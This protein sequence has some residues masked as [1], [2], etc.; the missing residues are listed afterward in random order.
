MRDAGSLSTSDI[1]SAK[2]REQN[3]R[4]GGTNPIVFKN[5]KINLIQPILARSQLRAYRA[6]LIG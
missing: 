1:G 5:G 3:G 2:K 4:L 6:L